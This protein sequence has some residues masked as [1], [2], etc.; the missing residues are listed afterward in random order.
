MSVYPSLTEAIAAGLFH[1]GC[2]HTLHA[3][4]PGLTRAFESTE[5]P[6][7]YQERQAQRVME[8]AMRRWKR[9]QVLA[10]SIGDTETEQFAQRNIARWQ[11]RM[12]TFL[13][14][15]GRMRQSGREVIFAQSRS[16]NQDLTVS[17]V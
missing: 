13:D 2:T 17:N 9:K 4:I 11:K 12:R 14:E 15:T 3:Y 6:E 1:P 7:G 5:N 8:R 10:A 16:Q